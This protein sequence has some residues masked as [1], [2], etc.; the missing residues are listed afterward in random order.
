MIEERKAVIDI[1]TGGFSVKK[2]GI[3]EIAM[4]I[5]NAKN[6]PIDY[7]QTLVK[8]YAQEDGSF[9][10]YSEKAFEVHGISMDDME[11]EGKIPEEVCREIYRLIELHNVKAF[12]CHNASFDTP[13]LQHFFNRFSSENNLDFSVNYC[14]MKIAKTLLN[15]D[16]YSLKSLC[17]FFEIENEQAHRAMSDTVA[18]AKAFKKLAEYEESMY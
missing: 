9:S 2:N 5:L 1:E 12:I 10:E 11:K 18:T 13:R 7:F 17:A 3:V 15:L 14:T 6:E 8:S 16:S 4:V